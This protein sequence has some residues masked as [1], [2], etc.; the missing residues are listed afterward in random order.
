[1]A[2]TL[3]LGPQVARHFF[4]GFF[5]ANVNLMFVDQA[6]FRYLNLVQHHFCKDIVYSLLVKYFLCSV[7]DFEKVLVPLYTKKYIL[8]H[9]FLN[10]TQNPD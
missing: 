7:T 4:G 2:F 10:K 9:V 8:K 5:S 1:M 6:E 3:A